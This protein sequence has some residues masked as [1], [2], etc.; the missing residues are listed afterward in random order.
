M[1]VTGRVA[2]EDNERN[3]LKLVRP[4]STNSASAG[5]PAVLYS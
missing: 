3:F 4:L 5:L 2:N 1:A